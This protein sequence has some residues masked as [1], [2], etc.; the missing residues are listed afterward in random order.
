MLCVR[1][2]RV[3]S[4]ALPAMCEVWAFCAHRQPNVL[5]VNR[6]GHRS[7]DV[8][9]PVLALPGHSHRIQPAFTGLQRSAAKKG[10]M[11]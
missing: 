10:G 1:A 4:A 3:V 6:S 9:E 8:V 5:L 11:R 7:V 2:A